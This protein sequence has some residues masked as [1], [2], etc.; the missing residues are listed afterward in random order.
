MS[1]VNRCLL[2]LNN[3]CASVRCPSGGVNAMT[4][5]QI[6]LVLYACLAILSFLDTLRSL[7]LAQETEAGIFAF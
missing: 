5:F 3:H 4:Q 6:N 1:L 2:G 7:I